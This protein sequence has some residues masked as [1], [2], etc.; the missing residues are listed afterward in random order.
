MTFEWIRHWLVVEFSV[1]FT[2]SITFNLV[3]PLLLYSSIIYPTKFFDCYRWSRIYGRPWMERWICSKW[4]WKSLHWKLQT[5]RV[6]E[7]SIPYR[8]K[9][10]IGIKISLFLIANLLTLHSTIYYIFRRLSMIV[11]IYDWNSK[12]KIR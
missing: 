12:I 10:S 3:L 2:F 11:Y 4:H 9:I 8:K 6:K 7:Y 1:T 5:G